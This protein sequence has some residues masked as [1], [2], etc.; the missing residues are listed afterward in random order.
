M[1]ENFMKTMRVVALYLFT[2]WILV[3]APPIGFFVGCYVI[4][5]NNG[6][7]LIGKRNRVKRILVLTSLFFLTCAIPFVGFLFFL[8]FDYKANKGELTKRTNM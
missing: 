1:F 4:Y 2:G 7:E 8:Y 6:N 5:K 3:Y